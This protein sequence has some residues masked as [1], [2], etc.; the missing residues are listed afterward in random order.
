[1][2]QSNLRD[3]HVLA[4]DAVFV[5]RNPK[6]VS[7]KGKCD[8]YRGVAQNGRQ[9]IV[10]VVRGSNPVKVVGVIPVE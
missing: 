5:Y 4:Q 7:A 8:E 2:A 6:A 1:M 10:R 9:L 3:R